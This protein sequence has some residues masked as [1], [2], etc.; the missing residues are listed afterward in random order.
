MAD[1]L[2]LPPGLALP[3]RR[4]TNGASPPRVVERIRHGAAI[5]DALE[6][7]EAQVPEAVADAEDDDAFL[8]LKFSADNR[9]APGPLNKRVD[10]CVTMC[11]GPSM[12]LN[13]ELLTSTQ[14]GALLGKS[15][16]TVIR[17]GESGK[18]PIYGKLPGPNGAYL[19]SKSDVDKLL[20]QRAAA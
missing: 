13:R 6:R 15:G 18:L 5:A 1:H 8:V 7:V 12:Q 20:A 4:S 11:N 10:C 16:R 17:M 9:L 3:S 19:F 14:V 2:P